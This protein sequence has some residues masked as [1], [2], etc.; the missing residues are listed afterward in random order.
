[1]RFVLV[2]AAAAWL[3]YT[4]YS[5]GVYDTKVMDD[6]TTKILAGEEVEVPEGGGDLHA[7]RR[8][9]TSPSRW[10]RPPTCTSKNE[11][12]GTWTDM[13]GDKDFLQDLVDGGHRPPRG[14]HRAAVGGR[15]LDGRVGGHRLLAAAYHLPYGRRAGRADRAR[16]AGKP[17][18]VDV[19]TGKTFEELQDDEKNEFDFESMFSVDEEALRGGLL[20]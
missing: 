13:T 1:M 11:E 8:A 9:W 10:C 2:P 6:M 20:V 17:R 16:A 5:L 15:Q 14:G 7:R 19:F 4:L 3:D 12:Q 18:N